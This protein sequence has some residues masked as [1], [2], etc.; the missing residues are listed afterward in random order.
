MTTVALVRWSLKSLLWV[1]SRKNKPNLGM[2]ACMHRLLP[3]PAGK[4]MTCTSQISTQ[5]MKW[6][7]KY[8]SKQ[9]TLEVSTGKNGQQGN[10]P[11]QVI[12]T[13]PLL[14][15]KVHICNKSHGECLVGITTFADSTRQYDTIGSIRSMSTIYNSTKWCDFGVSDGSPKVTPLCDAHTPPNHQTHRH[16]HFIS[17]IEHHSID[18]AT[19]C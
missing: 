9:T 18:V 19:R 2:K 11:A 15:T 4:F 12:Q 10:Q 6:C 13:C 7:T 8:Q 17:A 3:T 5:K 1:F 16:Q 14:L